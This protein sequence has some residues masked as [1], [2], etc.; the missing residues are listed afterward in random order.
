MDMQLA[1]I[2][3][4]FGGLVDPAAIAAAEAAKAR[5]QSAYM[6]AIHR[7]RR[8]D[9]AR[10]NVIHAC[11]RPSFAE[12]VEYSKPVGDRKITGPSI[13]LIELALKEWGNVLVDSQVIYEDATTRRI[14]VT[15]T[16]LESNTS[17]SKEIQIGKTVERKS[18]KGRE[19]VS[20]RLN[21][22]GE[23]VYVVLATED[24]ISNKEA[25][26]ISKTIR[27]EGRRI[28]PSDLIEE[29][30]I[31]AKETRSRADKTD[32]DAARKKIADAFFGIGV[33]PVQ[34]EE[35]L[36]HPMAQLVPSE[37]EQLRSI[38]SAIKEG[39]ARWADYTQKDPDSTDHPEAKTKT[40]EKV[41][42]LKEKIKRGRE[43]KPTQVETELPDDFG[44]PAHESLPDQPK[45]EC[46][47][48]GDMIYE[49]YCLEDCQ[50]REGCPAWE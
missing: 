25:A 27:N 14:R 2:Q 44:A 22:Y 45:R 23:T 40:D 46:P 42:A 15:V 17:Q 38:Y 24:E 28:L 8:P 19:I 12:S 35:F 6:M 39:E 37:L 31:T 33:S 18:S 4:R 1:P 13:R 29:A 34:I 11:R 50:N 26:L 10:V 48:S 41:S 36:G 21:S 5:I 30:M 49:S 9:Q 43:R 32:P 7:P 3:E 47:N 16:D 20:Q